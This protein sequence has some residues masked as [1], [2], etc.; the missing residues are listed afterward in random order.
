MSGY[1][2]S[3]QTQGTT[4]MYINSADV[5]NIHD[6]SR[7]HFTYEFKDA[8]TTREGEAMLVSLISASIP[9]SFY[10][11]R[12]DVND[13]IGVVVTAVDGTETQHSLTLQTGNYTATSLKAQVEAFSQASVNIPTVVIAF[14]T[15]DLKYVFSLADNTEMRTV[16]FQFRPFGGGTPNIEF[17]FERDVVLSPLASGGVPETSDRCVDING[18]IHSVFVR[19]NLPTRSI[20]DSQTGGISDILGNIMVNTDPGRVIT[21]TSSN[22]GHESLIHTSHVRAITIKLTDERNRLLDLNGL[23]FQVA[24]QFKFVRLT[25][26]MRDQM[27]RPLLEDKPPHTAP[28]QTKDKKSRRRNTLKKG[29]HKVQ[30]AMEVTKKIQEA[31]SVDFKND[32]H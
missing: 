29:K 32:R 30:R 19:T 24:I 1:H 31:Q 15:R 11:I 25:E 16:T 12:T 26:A 20:Y 22:A 14:S 21:L 6:A 3:H 28:T 18:S 27:R 10:N 4:T 9:Y 5:P 23:N 8:I 2:L 7:S 13:R 17:G